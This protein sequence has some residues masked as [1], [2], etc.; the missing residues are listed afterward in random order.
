[1]KIAK[2][3]ME[4]DRAKKL[5]REYNQVLKTRAKD[6]Q[7][8][9]KTIKSCYY[10]LSKGRPIID[11]FEVFRKT[12]FNDKTSFPILAFAPAKFKTVYFRQEIIQASGG[13]A[14][15][16][17]ENWDRH[18]DKKYWEF[19]LNVFPRITRTRNLCL[20]APVPIIPPKFMPKKVEGHYLLWEV[21]S[22]EEMKPKRDPILLKH[23]DHHLYCIVASWSLTNVERMITSGRI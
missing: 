5:W 6:Y 15:F 22:W 21:E 2:T 19:E 18:Y 14:K 20:K 10:Q 23:I 13:I 8:E 11:I 16:S 9:V 1:M 17:N 3:T 12:N 4:K 7:A